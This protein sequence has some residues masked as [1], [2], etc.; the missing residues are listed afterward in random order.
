MTLNDV[1]VTKGW[2]EEGWKKTRKSKMENKRGGGEGF[3][4]VVISIRA[5]I[6]FNPPLSPS[7]CCLLMREN[8]EGRE[9]RSGRE[10]P[11]S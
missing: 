5:H 6:G 11:H 7:L 1:S 8:E 9:G 4:S 3:M 10:I 2:M